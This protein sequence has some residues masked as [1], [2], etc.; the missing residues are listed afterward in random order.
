MRSWIPNAITMG[1]LVCGCM[2]ILTFQEDAMLSILWVI[3]AAVL[4]F[5][6]GL[7]A[8]ALGVS[9]ALGGQLDS[10]ADVVSFGVVPSLWAHQLLDHHP[11]QNFSF[12]IAV[13]AAYRLGRF[14]LDT[15]KVEHFKG[16]PVP[17][18]ALVWVA[19]FGY[20]WE[21]TYRFSPVA[22]L[23]F[24]IFTALL[25]ASTL[26][27]LNLKFKGLVWKGQEIRWI[28]ILMA[29]LTLLIC[30]GLEL[31]IFATTMIIATEYIILS[32]FHF[33]KLSS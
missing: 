20:A 9:S 28:L 10:L 17:A 15:S 4:D 5:F 23:C 24:V 8:R 7:A 14:N 27:L 33:K 13:G 32:M 19:V 26:P 3:T 21:E 2:A 18:N 31:S 29:A 6:D 22:L 16:L 25:M 1:N 11:L 30:Q 12:L